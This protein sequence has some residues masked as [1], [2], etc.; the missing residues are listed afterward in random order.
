MEFSY[1]LKTKTWNEPKRN[2]S[3][4]YTVRIH[5]YVVTLPDLKLEEHRGIIFY[6]NLIPTDRIEELDASI[7]I[8]EYLMCDILTASWVYGK[9]IW[10]MYDEVFSKVLTYFCH[11]QHEMH[12]KTLVELTMRVAKV[13]AVIEQLASRTSDLDELSRIAESCVSHGSAYKKDVS[14][15]T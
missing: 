9:S 2:D 6:K 4:K 3:K 1:D 15:N 11:H 8:E 12:S 13:E 10:T 14:K 5:D 7:C